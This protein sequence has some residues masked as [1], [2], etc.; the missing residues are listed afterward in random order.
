LSF[1]PA[2]EA[3]DAFRDSANA[4]STYV[5]DKDA[6]HAKALIATAV[7]TVREIQV[8]EGPHIAEADD[9]VMTGMEK[10]MGTSEAA[11]RSALQALGPLI[12]PASRPGLTEASA[13]LDRFLA[14][15]AQIMAL[16][17]QNTNVRSLALSLDEK[18][19]LID[20]CEQSLHALQDALAKRGYPKGR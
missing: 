6:W 14:L 2:Q 15:H 11:A 17:R 20:P 19:K 12:R 13:N 7:L 18:R 3:A 16:S 5:A 1:G 10:R 8:M 4:L 9:E